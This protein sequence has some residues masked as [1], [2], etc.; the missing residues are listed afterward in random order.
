M[1]AWSVCV[2]LAIALVAS[3]CDRAPSGTELAREDDPFEERWAKASERLSPLELRAEEGELAGNATGAAGLVGEAVGGGDGSGP[4]AYDEVTRYVRTKMGGIQTCYHRAS[5][6]HPGLS[7]RAL[8][9]FTVTPAG[10]VAEV[11]VDAPRFGGT[12]LGT[13]VES[14]VK[15]WRFRSYQ[16]EPLAA[17]YPL[18]FVGR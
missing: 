14:R 8:L 16:G 5:R 9:N 2:G 6:T 15:T 7:G 4:L 3:G 13:C 17:S 12:P 11:D 10:E 1:R 18:V